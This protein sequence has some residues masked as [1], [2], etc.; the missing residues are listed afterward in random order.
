MGACLADSRP[1]ADQQSFTVNK[2]VDCSLTPRSQAE[3]LSFHEKSKIVSSVYF[4]CET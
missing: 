4:R 1:N 3:I 2:Q